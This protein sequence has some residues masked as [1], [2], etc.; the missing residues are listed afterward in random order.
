MD[1]RYYLLASRYQK[2]Q[3]S[4]TCFEEVEYLIK[5]FGNLIIL[6]ALKDNTTIPKIYVNAPLKVKRIWSHYEYNKYTDFS[7]TP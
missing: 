7:E 4:V 2:I 1:F 6:N 3:V 5:T